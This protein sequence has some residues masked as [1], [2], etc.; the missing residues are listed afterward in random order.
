MAKVHGRNIDG[1]DKEPVGDIGGAVDEF[2]SVQ[3]EIRNDSDGVQ[4]ESK[5]KEPEVASGKDPALAREGE[6]LMARDMSKEKGDRVKVRYREGTR[7]P[8]W[9]TVYK[10]AIAEEFE[11]RG[12]VDILDYE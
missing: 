9:V 2:E 4:E 6:K 7:A 3:D 12:M 10:K 11:R 1:A 5:T 8:G